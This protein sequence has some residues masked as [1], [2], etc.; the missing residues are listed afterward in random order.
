VHAPERAE[1]VSTEGAG[2][3]VTRV[4]YRLADGR[5]VEWTSR[6]H[7]KHRGHRRSWWAPGHLGWWVAALFIVGSACFA[8]GALP[9]YSDAAGVHADA[10][11]Y[12]VGSIFFTSA[13][14]L[15]FVQCINTDPVADGARHWRRRLFA[16]EPRRI[17]WWAT[18][19]QLVG[20]VFFNF[21]T[22]DAFL[23]GLDAR[24]ENLVV[25]TPDALGSLCFLISS[26]LAYAEA[27]HGW[28]SWR[29]RDAGW[30]IAALNMLGSIFFGISAVAGYV[31]PSTGSVV[32]AAVD[33]SGT[34]WGA[35]CFL[36][37]SMLLIP[38]AQE[39][40]G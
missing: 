18:A 29:I 26:E 36:A 30:R 20:T 6:A 24:Q 38:E 5:L 14:Y 39:K 28:I 7:R 10:M 40:P 27:G 8:V 32:N 16:I 11:T 25:W 33:T 1:V 2:P 3:F 37:A 19:V 15:Q 34:F 9:G 35:V 13:S 22:F 12:F 21:T 23:Q 31:V 4:R 17:D